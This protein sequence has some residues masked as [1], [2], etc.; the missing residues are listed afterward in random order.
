[1]SPAPMWTLVHENESRITVRNSVSLRLAQD[2]GYRWVNKFDGKGLQSI[3]LIT[4][5][6]AIR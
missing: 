1:M 6:G 5:N 2:S 4:R 3:E